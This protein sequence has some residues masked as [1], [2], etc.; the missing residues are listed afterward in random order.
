[1]LSTLRQQYQLEKDKNDAQD[2]QI[3]DLKEQIEDI[4]LKSQADQTE[5]LP[6]DDVKKIVA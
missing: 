3:T 5:S 1:M 6:I 2:S 4:E